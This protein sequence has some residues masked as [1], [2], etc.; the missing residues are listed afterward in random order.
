MP[1]PLSVEPDFVRVALVGTVTRD[2]L[3]DLAAEAAR[4]EAT[5]DPT[6]NRLVDFSGALSLEVGYPDVQLVANRR[7]ASRLRNAVRSA[8]VVRSRADFGL[9]RMFQTLN[10]HPQIEIRI[11]DDTPEAEAW[12]TEGAS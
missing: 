1:F 5:F 4:I 6:P 2:D 10:D 9:V 7:R 12:L 3:L 8:F 11:F